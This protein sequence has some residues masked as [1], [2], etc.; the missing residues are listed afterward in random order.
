MVDGHNVRVGNYIYNKNKDVVEVQ[1]R[2]HSGHNKYDFLCNTNLKEFASTDLKA[3]SDLDAKPIPINERFLRLLGFDFIVNDI[4]QGDEF[5]FKVSPS[6]GGTIL[7]DDQSGIVIDYV[8]QLQN[9]YFKTTCKELVFIGDPN[10]VSDNCKESETMSA[11]TKD[12]VFDAE[13]FNALDAVLM[14][15]NYNKEFKNWLNDVLTK[16]YAAAENGK[17]AIEVDCLDNDIE[18]ELLKRGFKI[19]T[20]Y[21][22]RSRRSNTTIIWYWA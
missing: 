11:N 14:A 19:E 20:K 7:F 10:K 4:W 1:I 6:G 5:K 22:N 3:L 12:I 17:P 13:T 8:H 9:Y 21:I 15:K 16:V 2:I 18:S